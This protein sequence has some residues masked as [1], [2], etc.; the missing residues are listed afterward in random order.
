MKHNRLPRLLRSW[1]KQEALAL[2]P[3]QQQRFQRVS[4]LL[5]VGLTA[6]N[7]QHHYQEQRKQR[8]AQLQQGQQVAAAQWDVI[9]ATAYDWAHWD[10]TH[11]YALGKA[12]EYPIRNLQAA[13]G[14]SS[15]APVVLILNRSNQLLTLQGRQGASSWLNDPL[16]LCS[17]SHAKR[18]IGKPRTFGISCHDR[19]GEHL[20]IGVIE[21]ITDTEEQETS[22]GLMVLL[23]PLRHPRYGLE[24]QALMAG[25]EQQL[26]LAP[27]SPQTM[28]LHAQSIWGDSKRVLTLRP[29]SVLQLALSGLTRDVALASPFLLLLLGLRGALMLQ[30]RGQHLQRQLRQRRSQQRLRQAKHKL[31]QLFDQLP[32]QER[33]RSLQALATM[34]AD[35]IDDLARRLEAYAGAMQRLQ[36]QET[37][38]TQILYAPMKDQEGSV[39]RLLVESGPLDEEKVQTALAG[40]ASLPAA[41]RQ[42]LGVQFQLTRSQWCNPEFITAMEVNRKRVGCPSEL[43]ILAGRAEQLIPCSNQL[44][45]TMTSLRSRGYH[46]ALVVSDNS[47]DPGLLMQKLP[48]DELQLSVPRQVTPGV[49]EPEQALFA[50][51]VHLGKARGLRVNAVNLQSKEQ[52]DLLRA[53]AIDQ[54]AGPLCGSATIDPAELLVPVAC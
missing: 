21:P 13:N 47:S 28:T 40:W 49:H 42:R 20:W 24:L 31:D 38:Q 19:E 26:E 54:L 15:V 33:E 53:L 29:Q 2:T 5:V 17:R 12:P 7:L 23:A 27:P 48:F 11:A 14:L 46:L 39:Q 36:G 45:E 44:L 9:R 16:V 34:Q 1:W 41:W 3:G 32:L 18:V 6:L 37:E 8:D 10:E 51:L 52:R 43:C 30:R 35:P 4:V 22:S 50:A 25:L